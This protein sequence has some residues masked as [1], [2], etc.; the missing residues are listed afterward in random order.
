MYDIEKM[1]YEML[2]ISER[3]NNLENKQ[4]FRTQINEHIRLLNSEYS[5]RRRDLINEFGQYSPQNQLNIKKLLLKGLPEKPMKMAKYL[6]YI[7][8]FI[9]KKKLTGF[10]LAEYEVLLR[11]LDLISPNDEIDISRI[12]AK[13]LGLIIEVL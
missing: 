13:I 1:Y 6:A 10:N 7:K 9:G 3:L 2:R 5:N 8:D 11:R 4:W 12:D